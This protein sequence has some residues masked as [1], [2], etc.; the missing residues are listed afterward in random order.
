MTTTSWCSASPSRKTRRLLPSASQGG[1]RCPRRS[2]EGEWHKARGC[3]G[4]FEGLVFSLGLDVV[5]MSI[6]VL[7]K[8]RRFE[9]ALLGAM[10]VPN[11][12]VFLPAQRSQPDCRRLER[13]LWHNYR[14]QDWLQHGVQV[15]ANPPRPARPCCTASSA[16]PDGAYPPADL[17]ADATSAPNRERRQ[18]LTS[19][20]ASFRKREG[21]LGRPRL[22]TS[23]AVGVIVVV[24]V[25]A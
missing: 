8:P 15:D 19:V 13:A 21:G 11:W 1:C 16:A 18:P 22:L 20:A 25:P 9:E 10:A 4:Q 14:R 24:R 6:P 3:S 5:R 2:D 7:I 17:I 12:I 23:V